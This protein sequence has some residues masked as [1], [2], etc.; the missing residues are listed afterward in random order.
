ESLGGSESGFATMMT[1]KARSLGMSRTTYV[2]ASGLPDGRQITTARDLAILGVAIQDRFPRY[3]RYF[4]T[5]S[6]VYQGRGIANH[7]RLV[8]NVDGVDGIKTGY[9]RASGFNLLTS[10]RR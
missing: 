1:R 7:N 6:F 2:N 3:F 4:A 5:R 9:T 8:G 10:L